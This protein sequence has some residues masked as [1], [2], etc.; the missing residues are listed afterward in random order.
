MIE[1]VALIAFPALLLLLCPGIRR[2]IMRVW[3]RR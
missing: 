1:A 3:R 2:E